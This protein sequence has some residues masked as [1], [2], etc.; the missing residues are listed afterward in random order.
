MKV[1]S[2]TVLPETPEELNPLKEIAYNMWYSWNWEAVKLFIA[3][4]PGYWEKSYQSPINMLCMLPLR[5]MEEAAR[6]QKFV[7]HMN[8]VYQKFQEY[9][10]EKP[11]F[12]KKFGERNKSLIAY[13]SC[14]YG[15]DEGLPLYSGGLGILAGDHM[16]SASDLGIPLMGVGLFYRQGYFKQYLNADGWQ[17]ES[18]P[19]NNRH[20]MPLTLER[21]KKGDP[22]LVDLSDTNISVKF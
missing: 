4:D 13:F 15:I 21:D 16:K 14:E 5:K 6:N 8:R 17:M 9:L 12:E 3:L 10:N 22:L 7:S 20:R 1:T 11:W 18:Y 2:F 19:A